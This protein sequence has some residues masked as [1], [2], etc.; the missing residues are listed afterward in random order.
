M[1]PQAEGHIRLIARSASGRVVPRTALHQE[2]PLPEAFPPQR[3]PVPCT[4][5]HPRAAFWMGRGST[6]RT[7]V[8]G[9]T[10]QSAWGAVF[11]A[12]LQRQVWCV[13]GCF[14]FLKEDSWKKGLG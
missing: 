5:A 12:W 6:S 2:E 14:G 8:S 3:V 10:Q 7:L 9:G 11:S 13:V 1:K 4:A